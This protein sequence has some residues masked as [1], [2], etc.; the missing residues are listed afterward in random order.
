MRA[1]TRASV[2]PHSDSPGRTRTA[3]AAWRAKLEA[4]FEAGQG[5]RSNKADW[6]DGAWSGIKVAETETTLTIGDNQGQKHILARLDID[7]QRASPLSTMPD[8]LEK[9]LTEQEFIDLIA[10]LVSRKETRPR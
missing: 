9:R 3:S 4:E 10:F 6:L 1:P 7:E 5:Y 8:G 2:A